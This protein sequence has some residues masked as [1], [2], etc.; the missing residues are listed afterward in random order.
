MSWSNEMLVRDRIT[1]LHAEAAHDRL[2]RAVSGPSRRGDSLQ[3]GGWWRRLMGL[4][5]P[6][7]TR[8]P[9]AGRIA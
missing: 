9:T 2:A 5:V 8:R 4:P 1:R 3:A 6:S 7:P